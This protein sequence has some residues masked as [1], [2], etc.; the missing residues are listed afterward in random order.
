MREAS[1]ARRERRERREERSTVLG[2]GRTVCVV[3]GAGVR[4]GHRVPNPDG[5]VDDQ[6]V[7]EPE[8]DSSAS[9]KGRLSLF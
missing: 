4:L 1:E 3:S 5:R 2:G 7:R 6:H 8:E 9:S